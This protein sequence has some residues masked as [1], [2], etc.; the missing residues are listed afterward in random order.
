ME[1]GR[2]TAFEKRGYKSGTTDDIPTIP[3]TK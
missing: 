3:S 2:N 1:M